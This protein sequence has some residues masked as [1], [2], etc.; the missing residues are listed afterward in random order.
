MV[1]DDTPHPNGGAAE[2]LRLLVQGE[3]KSSHF[4]Q[5]EARR[6]PTWMARTSCHFSPSMCRKRGS[7]FSS[8]FMT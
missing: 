7:G 5:T 2:A 8:S 4:S 6:S 3:V 1:G